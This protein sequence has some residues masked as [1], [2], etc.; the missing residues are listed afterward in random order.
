MFSHT[1]RSKL[2]FIYEKGVIK[3]ALHWDKMYSYEYIFITHII[4]AVTEET[5][6]LALKLS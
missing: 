1:M 4:P 2:D 5:F 6:I 3:A